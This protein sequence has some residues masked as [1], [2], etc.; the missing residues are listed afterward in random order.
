MPCNISYIL[1]LFLVHYCFLSHFSPRCKLS[2][3]KQYHQSH[4]LLV[5]MYSIYFLS[6]G[7]SYMMQNWSF[8]CRTEKNMFSI[9][10]IAKSSDFLLTVKISYKLGPTCLLK[11][12][13]YYSPEDILYF[14]F[15]TTFHMSWTFLKS[16]H[17][18]SLAY[19]TPIFFC[20]KLLPLFY[21]LL[22]VSN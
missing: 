14:N 3:P 16:F 5:S 6:H 15:N 10:H 20:T 11:L 7:Y 1:F 21:N 19:T 13:P 18:H 4:L 2:L 22:N 17:L 9:I 12:L 8:Y